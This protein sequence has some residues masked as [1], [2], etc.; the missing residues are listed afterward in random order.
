MIMRILWVAAMGTF[1]LQPPWHV[2]ASDT[3]AE[4]LEEQ[5]LKKSQNLQPPE[6]NSLERFFYEFKERRVLERYQAGFMGFHPLIGG[7]STGSGWALGTQF[8]KTEAL[9]GVFDIA[10]SAQASFA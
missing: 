1:L 10:A 5:R 8:R 3:R 4:R 9:P 7:L 6:R 2:F